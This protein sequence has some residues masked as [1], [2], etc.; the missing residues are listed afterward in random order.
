[1][2]EMEPRYQ[3]VYLWL[4]RTFLALERFPEALAILEKGRELTGPSP[5]LLSIL[6]LA[7]AR[8]GRQAE[9][10]AILQQF[11]D[12][13]GQ[14]WVSPFFESHV[15]IGLGDTDGALR[16]L[17]NAYQRRSGFIVVLQVDPLYDEIRSEP[18]F[19]RLLQ[20]VGLDHH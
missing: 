8:L 12:T 16:L 9:A 15:L 13:G 1:M 11:R 14:R 2:L 20:K 17:E 7:Y 3:L 19:Q 5:N 10:L 18:R 6:G 4:G